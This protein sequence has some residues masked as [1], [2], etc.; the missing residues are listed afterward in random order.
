VGHG[1]IGGI[2]VDGNKFTQGAWPDRESH[3]HY[4]EDIMSL[5]PETASLTVWVAPELQMAARQAG[6]YPRWT[7]YD[8][9]ID[10]V[11]KSLDAI[12]YPHPSFKPS[13]IGIS[14]P[15]IFCNWII[16]ENKHINPRFV[17]GKDDIV[18]YKC[19]PPQLRTGSKE[20]SFLFQPNYGG[21]SLSTTAELMTNIADI[22]GAVFD[23]KTG[24]M[25]LYGTKDL[26]LP[27]MHL[28]DLAVAIRSVYGLGGRPE[29]DP[30]ISMDPDPHKKK[31]HP[32]MTVTYYGETK[33]TRFGQ[34][35]FEADRL[36]KN[37]M[38]GR[39]N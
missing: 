15:T 8:N 7:P 36:L 30:G 14:D 35:M 1:W 25:I 32:Q 34:V 20:H 2:D 29:Q 22:S 21:I 12:G 10:H 23:Q 19:N 17:L 11:V 5:C 6:N 3:M 39:N 4:N 37:L 16:E 33:D 24:Q 31:K 26:S 13:P 9:C 28:D 27:Q 38:L 18:P